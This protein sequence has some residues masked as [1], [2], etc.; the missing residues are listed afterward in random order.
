MIE[1]ETFRTLLFDVAHWEFEIFVTLVFDGL[2]RSD[3]GSASH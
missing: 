3:R 1:H 2:V